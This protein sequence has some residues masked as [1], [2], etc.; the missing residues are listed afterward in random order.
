MLCVVF[1]VQ[2]RAHVF[3]HYVLSV[4]VVEFIRCQDYCV[5]ILFSF[6]LEPL[7]VLT[8]FLLHSRLALAVVCVA[9]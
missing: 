9:F 1:D 4:S 7:E 2:F 8:A 5:D 6:V 3:A